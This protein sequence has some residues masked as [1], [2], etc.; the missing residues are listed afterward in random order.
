MERFRSVWI[1]NGNVNTVIRWTKE[2]IIHR[3]DVIMKGLD[4]QTCSKETVLV[5]SDVKWAFKVYNEEVV[6]NI[7]ERFCLDVFDLSWFRDELRLLMESKTPTENKK[8]RN[9]L[10]FLGE[11]WYILQSIWDLDYAPYNKLWE[12]TLMPGYIIYNLLRN[13]LGAFWRWYSDGMHSILLDLLWKNESMDIYSCAEV[14]WFDKRIDEKIWVI[15]SYIVGSNNAYLSRLL[16]VLQNRGYISQ[17]SRKDGFFIPSY[18]FYE[19]FTMN[20][21]ERFELIN[22]LSHEDRGVRFDKQKI[23]KI[24]E[25]LFDL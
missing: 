4:T 8:V 18:W 17:L 20:S 11:T 6:A 23:E 16:N 3:I 15:Q 24:L 9:L 25:E 22:K 12:L 1:S 7:V 21:D 5:Y 19:I 2:E 13:Q 14:L 10:D